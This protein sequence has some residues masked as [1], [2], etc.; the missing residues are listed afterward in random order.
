MVPYAATATIT[1]TGA[2][3]REKLQSNTRIRVVTSGIRCASGGLP[4][5]PGR[6][7]SGNSRG[8][9]QYRSGVSHQGIWPL[10]A[11]VATAAPEAVVHSPAQRQQMAQPMPEPAPILSGAGGGIFFFHSLGAPS[12]KRPLQKCQ[13][14]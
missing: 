1:Q 13:K 11:A 5:A 2:V 12:S 10:A 4:S 7:T 8:S 14:T 9:L 3:R 6:Q